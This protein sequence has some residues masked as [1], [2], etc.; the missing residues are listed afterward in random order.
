[1]ASL[2]DSGNRSCNLGYTVVTGPDVP[3]RRVSLK[4]F[5]GLKVVEGGGAV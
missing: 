5:V 1:M 4:E 3:V 2:S